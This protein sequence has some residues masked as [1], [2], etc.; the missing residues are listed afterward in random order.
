MKRYGRTLLLVLFSSVFLTACS[1][2]KEEDGAKMV[3]KVDG[4]GI[5]EQQL[6]YA[7]S[8]IPNIQKDKEDEARK[9]LLKKM[10][11]QQILVKQA[12]DKKLDQNPVVLQAIDASRR[13]LLAQAYLDQLAQQIPKATDAEVH[14]F[15]VKSPNLFSDRRVYKLGEII[16]SAPTQAEQIK[17]LLSSTKTMEEFAGKLHDAGIAFKTAAAVKAAEEL[18][19]PLLEKLAK[20][21]K[22]EVSMTPAGDGISLLQL[23]DFRE[24]PLTEDH[25]KT[26]ILNFLFEEKRKALYETEMKKLRDAAKVEYMGAYAEAGKAL[27]SPATPSPAVPPALVQPAA[28]GK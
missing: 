4:N 3:A 13:Q 11:D 18:P 19:A 14:E 9:Q 20:M 26:A 24:Q 27:L 8:R 22:G 6:D 17:Q 16:I 25:A 5:T 10:V 21:R 7:L 12:I 23:Q 1:Q 28:D 15:Y 2:K